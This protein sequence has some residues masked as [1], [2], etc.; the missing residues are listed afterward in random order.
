MVYSV[1]P[2]SV[3]YYMS[4]AELTTEEFAHSAREHRAIENKLEWQKGVAM[5]A[6][7][8]RIK[9]GNAAEMLTGFRLWQLIC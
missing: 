8:C 6:G 5:S 2:P 9:T 3:R 1:Q 4:P 7:Y